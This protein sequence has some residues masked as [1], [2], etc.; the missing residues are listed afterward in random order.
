MPN[1]YQKNHTFSQWST[2]GAYLHFLYEAGLYKLITGIECEFL[3]INTKQIALFDTGAEIYNA[4]E[5]HS[6]E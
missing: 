4:T 2:G 1:L 6:T 5:K 3:E